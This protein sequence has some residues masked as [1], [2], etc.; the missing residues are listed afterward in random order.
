V[1]RSAGRLWS[2]K[3]SNVLPPRSATNAQGEGHA[4]MESLENPYASPETLDTSTPGAT[5]A[6]THSPELTRTR[7]GLSLVYFGICT[8]ILS[9]IITV[10]AA[11]VGPLLAIVGTVG[12]RAG[13]L[14]TLV[15]PLFCLSVP[16]AT[17]ARGLIVASVILQLTFYALSIAAS[18]VTFRVPLFG[19]ILMNGTGFAATVLF[20]L[21]LRRLAEYIGRQDLAKRARNVLLLIVV[22]ILVTV[23]FYGI[24]PM[25]GG[26]ARGALAAIAM[27]SGVIALI[28][29][30]MY[31]NLVDGLRK[32]LG[33]A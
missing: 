20:L 2:I 7:H 1:R 30:V 12:V 31:A 3:A 32:S 19:V 17:G 28:A 33:A 21:F 18:V 4:S 8:I 10:V 27:G 5:W 9:V 22:V 26:V 14:M 15:G 6:Y 24:I 16:T 13:A 29:F 11:L 23:A 25:A